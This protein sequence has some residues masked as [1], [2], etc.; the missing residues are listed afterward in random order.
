MPSIYDL[1]DF[2]DDDLDPCY[3][4]D[5]LNVEDD[6]VCGDPECDGIACDPTLDKV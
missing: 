1:D 6:C 5:Y 2:G 4:T 3:D